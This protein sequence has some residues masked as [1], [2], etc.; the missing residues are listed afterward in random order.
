ML[1]NGTAVTTRLRKGS[2]VHFRVAAVNK[3][4]E[5]FPSQ[6]L[7]ACYNSDKAKSILIVDGFHRLSSPAVTTKSLIPFGT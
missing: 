6:V 3:G 4:G 5:S 2:L 7:S 1:V